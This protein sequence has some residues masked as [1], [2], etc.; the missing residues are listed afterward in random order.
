M[1]VIIY[2]D[3]LQFFEKKKKNTTKQKNQKQYN[4]NLQIKI[5]IT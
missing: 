3:C 1:K 4:K 2:S 5:T